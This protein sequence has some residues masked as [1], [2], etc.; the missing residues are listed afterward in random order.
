MF[1]VV[2]RAADETL[3]ESR[4]VALDLALLGGNVTID[5]VVRHQRRQFVAGLAI[6]GESHVAL[7]AVKLPAGSVQSETRY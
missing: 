6:N 3:T 1:Y 5:S 2:K 7:L 4:S